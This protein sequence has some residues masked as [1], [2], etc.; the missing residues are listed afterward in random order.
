MNVKREVVYGAEL[1]GKRT[2]AC[3]V[4][5]SS[6]GRGSIPHSMR[7]NRGRGNQSGGGQKFRTRFARICI[8]KYPPSLKSWDR[9]YIGPYV[10]VVCTA[11]IAGVDKW[12]WSVILTKS[13]T[14]YKPLSAKPQACMLVGMLL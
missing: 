13:Q 5:K 14:N 1:T 6:K 9:H 11:A 4:C 8:A 3:A 7:L 10:V 2:C 12:A